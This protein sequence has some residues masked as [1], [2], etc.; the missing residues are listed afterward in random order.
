MEGERGGGFRAERLRQRRT[1]IYCDDKQSEAE[2][3]TNEE[4]RREGGIN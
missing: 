4:E 1:K 3:N 2:T